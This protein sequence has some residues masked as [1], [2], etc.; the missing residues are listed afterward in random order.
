MLLEKLGMANHLFSPLE[1]SLAHYNLRNVNPLPA[2]YL[3]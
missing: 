3:T 2:S 1:H